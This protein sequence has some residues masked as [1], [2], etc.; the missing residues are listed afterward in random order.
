VIFPTYRQGAKTDLTTLSGGEA[1]TE[2]AGNVANME[3]VGAAAIPILADVVEASSCY[4][5][6][7]G[8]LD[9]AVEAAKRVSLQPRATGT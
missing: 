6:V 9:E 1:M 2:L 7:S 5:L 8:A 4:R 3:I